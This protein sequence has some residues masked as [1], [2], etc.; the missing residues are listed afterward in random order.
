MKIRLLLPAASALTLAACGSLPESDSASD[1]PDVLKSSV[2]ATLT[3]IVP[4][5]LPDARNWQCSDGNS[6]QTRLQGQ[7]LQLTYQ[8]RQYTLVRQPAARPAI[9]QNR[10][11]IFSSNG[12]SAV[13][14]KPYSSIIYSAGCLPR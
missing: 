5:K 12:R 1:S 10:D 6:V 14:G 11:L 4:V 3:A 2:P 9:Y 7:Q 8:G 13:I